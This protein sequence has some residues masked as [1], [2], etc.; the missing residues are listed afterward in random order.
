MALGKNILEQEDDLKG[1]PDMMLEMELQNPTGRYPDFLVMSEIQRRGQMR[2]RFMAQQ[3]VMPPVKDQM[4]ANSPLSQSGLMVM[5][6]EGGKFPDLSG[7]GE[8]TKKDILMGRGVIPMQ[9]GGG[10]ADAATRKVLGP[11]VGGALSRLTALG[12]DLAQ[13]TAE[14]L[15]ELQR[16]VAE[17]PSS[18]SDSQLA[19]IAGAVKGGLGMLVPEVLS[20]TERQ[21]G[22]SGQMQTGRGDMDSPSLVEY[23]A[24]LGESLPRSNLGETLSVSS[25]VEG[26]SDLGR[27]DRG[28]FIEDAVAALANLP[29]VPLTR[30]EVRSNLAESDERIRQANED[31]MQARR[32]RRDAILNREPMPPVEDLFPELSEQLFP[33]RT[34]VGSSGQ[35]RRGRSRADDERSSFA[36]MLGLDPLSIEDVRARNEEFNVKA[37]EA[38]EATLERRRERAE[39]IRNQEPRPPVVPIADQFRDFISGL[40]GDSGEVA[41]SVVG[42][43]NTVGLGSEDGQSLINQITSDPNRID[44]DAP[45]IT[46]DPSDSGAVQNDLSRSLNPLIQRQLDLVDELGESTTSQADAFRQSIAE[47]QKQAKDRAFTSALLQMSAN[48]GANKPTFEGVGDAFSE[49]LQSGDAA[50][51]PLQ[52]ALLQQPTQTIKD[53]L[54]A[55][56]NVARAD[57]QYR[58]ILALQEVEKG[59]AKR[60]T[61]ATSRAYMKLFTDLL[62]S[63]EFMLEIG[64]TGD[65]A[66]E[67]LKDFIRS[68]PGVDTD[69]APN[70]FGTGGGES[71][72]DNSEDASSQRPPMQTYFQ[73][74]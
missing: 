20:P 39:A 36:E 65:N 54:D 24:G 5:A 62:T 74:N 34:A 38:N 51:R 21:A 4:I 12:I 70:L 64:A 68:L 47:I 17:A 30:D 14:E 43:D 25:I 6:A 69:F 71:S 35:M 40:F 3:D 9:E 72:S 45:I 50:I 28:Q 63:P 56:S 48:I 60:D 18:V 22:T 29:D 7:D 31:T 42:S 59:R 55:L 8:V 49:Q 11:V 73:S 16:R 58:N 15:R 33:D 13:F 1:F 57:A 52:A 67:V 19:D 32:D 46:T 26:M 41:E 2:D 10:L 23:M 66:Q 27:S 53:K 61:A 37:R 44:T